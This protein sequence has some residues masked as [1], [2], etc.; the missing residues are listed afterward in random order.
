[1]SP[2]EIV[3]L[4]ISGYGGRISGRTMLQKV[5]Y[6][7]GVNQADVDLDFN[8]HYYGPFSPTVDQALSELKNLQLVMEDKVGF[9]I[10]GGF[11]E[12]K[13]YDYRLTDGGRA[14]LRN[15]QARKPAQCERVLTVVQRIRDSGDPDYVILSV[16]AKS[17]FI[18]SR[19]KKAMTPEQI[20][21]AAKTFDWNLQEFSVNKALELL[22]RLNLVSVN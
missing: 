19:Q 21:M 17:F 20:K 18:L 11:G 22:Q 13:R 12:M 4:V 15:L 14:V 16:A 7:V 9:G 1:M 2:K 3:L 10:Q 5:C 8:A 6:F